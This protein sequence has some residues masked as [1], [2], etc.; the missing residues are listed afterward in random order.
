MSTV[1]PVPAL[2]GEAHRAQG[3]V[4]AVLPMEALGVC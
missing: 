3:E 1:A 2:V 4:G